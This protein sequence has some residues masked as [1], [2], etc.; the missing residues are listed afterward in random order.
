LCNRDHWINAL[1][2]RH[3]LNIGRGDAENATRELLSDQQIFKRFQPTRE[4]EE[5]GLQAPRLVS[6]GASGSESLP[7]SHTLPQGTPI[8]T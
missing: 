5:S 6:L 8:P 1:R 7:P 2:G 4:S 3:S